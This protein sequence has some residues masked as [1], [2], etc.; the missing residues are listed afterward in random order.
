L[1]TKLLTRIV[2]RFLSFAIIILTFTLSVF[3]Q[4]T[5]KQNG[6]DSIILSIDTTKVDTTIAK[7]SFFLNSK[8]DYKA[9][10]SILMDLTI[11]KVYLYKNAEINYENINLKAAYIEI[12]FSKNIV[13]AKGVIDSTGK[14]IGR[15]IFAENQQTFK[16]HRITYNYKTKKGI[17]ENVITKEGDGYLHGKY[18]KKMPS[19]ETHIK[20]GKYT[21]CSLEHPHYEIRFFKA[22]VIPDDKIV[23]GPAYLV[24]ADIPTP[25]IIPFGF[26]PNKK[27]Q[28][29]GIL[30]PT[31]GESANRGFFL[32][33]GGYY[34]GINDRVD[35]AL[36]GDIYSRGS[37][38]VKA[39]SNYNKRYKYSGSI[40]AN[41]AINTTGEKNST[42]YSKNTDFFIRWNHNQSSKARP[43]S[44]FAAN[45]N[46][47]SSKYNQFNPAN[48]SDRLANT[49]SSNISYSKT[50]SDKYNLS[51]NFRHTQNTLNNTVN[52]NIPELTF[53]V[54][55]F[56]PLRKKSKTGK[57]KWYDNINV[58]YVMNA[59]N[60]LNTY[61]SLLFNDTE[62]SDFK[63]GVKHNIPINSSIKLLK[64]L[65]WTN[66][67]NYTE[68]WYFNSIR[69]DWDNGLLI[70]G[71]DTTFGF[72]RTDT[73]SGFNAARDFIFT[74]SVNTRLYGMYQF[75][76]GPV[77]A[78]R[79]VISP[80]INFAYRPDFSEEKW[81]Y[82]KYYTDGNSGRQV[83]YSIYD[84]Y[85]YQTPPSG[86]YGAV[87]F[88]L[89]NNLEMKVKS[90]KDTVNH[91]R[92]I[93]LIENLTISTS[94][95]FAKDS[96]NLSPFSISGY[97]KLFN[98]LD[99]RYA[100]IWDPYIINDST[101]MNINKFE[102]NV[103]KRLF[104]KKSNQW[105]LGLNF[106]LSSKK[107]S[108]KKPKTSEHGT[109]EEL[110]QINDNIDNYVDYDNPWTIN[111]SYTMRYMRNYN[112]TTGTFDKTFIQTLNFNGD[113]SITKKWKVGFRSGY[114]FINKGFSYTSIDIYR[115]L[116]CW[117][118][119][120]NW[121]PIG[122][123]KS[124]NFTINVKASVLQDLK[125]TKK[126][127]WRDY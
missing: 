82:Y 19:D 109:E 70:S 112:F 48:T 9:T 62:F 97:T 20:S 76:K 43:N 111:L 35:L 91:E 84:Q 93:K 77:K 60:E 40:N 51:A 95:N 36:R 27:G 85:I 103:N 92:K 50:F 74:S 22:K 55:R 46:A 61:D 59:K 41:Y 47:G 107:D 37:W 75:K 32:E 113:L 24:I 100:S 68:R 42:N 98:N 28:S 34:W 80:N 30:I 87:N 78:L 29:N 69:K 2:K 49:F 119:H 115:D 125:L 89:S 15:P 118:M 44:R 105:E 8:I 39:N 124:Y 99:I 88:A 81:G 52:L 96:L 13:F 120:F 11:Q 127:D 5:I 26:F 17:I 54:N 79:H 12:N 101:G 33:N 56:Y 64:H 53:S 1:L 106:H 25:L 31:Y 58:N 63:N 18:V 3:S 121:I 117:E 122:A 14:E 116:H 67:V 7:Q 90:K 108:E 110:K 16:A 73:I 123:W 10:D 104:R 94:Y 45:V 114:D 66:S 4:D 65:T 57:L 72:L 102:W 23:T 86:K 83:Q 38:G 21:T 71:N 126:K 6:N